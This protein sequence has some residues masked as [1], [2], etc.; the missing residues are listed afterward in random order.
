MFLTNYDDIVT[1]TGG[2]VVQGAVITV[3][4]W[5]GSAVSIYG[6][7]TGAGGA[8][9]GSQVT[10]N[11]YGTFSFYA[12]PGVYLLT[13]SN[14]PGAPVYDYDVVVGGVES[15]TAEYFGIREGAAGQVIT[16]ALQSWAYALLEHSSGTVASG[17]L[18]GGRIDLPVG[19]FIT[20]SLVWHP[21][22]SIFGA[23]RAG[24]QLTLAS[25]S[26]PIGPDNVRAMFYIL[27]R[28]QE[29]DPSGAWMPG[30]KHIRLEGNKTNQANQLSYGIYCERGQNDPQ[31]NAYLTNG[32]AK[33]YSAIHGENI[34]VEE[35]TGDG[36][37]F[38]GDRQRLMLFGRTR[39]VNHG[40]YSGGV[41]V[42]EGC[43]VRI[44]GNDPVISDCGFGSNT[45]HGVLASGCS[46][47]ILHGCNVWGA[48]SQARSNQCLALHVQNCNGFNITGNVFNDTVSFFGSALSNDD[49]GFSFTGNHCKPNK[50]TLGADGTPLG[51]ADSTCNAFIRVRGYKNGVIGPNDYSADRDGYRFEYLATFTEDSACYLEFAASSSESPKIIKPWMT[52]NP[53]P[54]MVDGSSTVSVV[55]HDSFRDMHRFSGQVVIGMGASNEPDP[56]YSLV[57]GGPLPALMKNRVHHEAGTALIPGM[58]Q[59]FESPSSGDNVVVGEARQ[60]LT[61]YSGNQLETLTVTLPDSPDDGHELDLVFRNGVKAFTLAMGSGSHVLTG[62]AITRVPPGTTIGLTFRATSPPNGEWW[63]TYT[64]NE[65]LEPR[66]TTQTNM[67][68]GG[69]LTADGSNVTVHLTKASTCT[70]FTV[71]LPVSPIDGERRRIVIHQEVTTWT[72]APGA[73][74]TLHTTDTWPTTIPAG[75]YTMEVQLVGTVWYRVH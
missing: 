7:R 39:S 30:F 67:T 61:V 12:R 14:V 35:F 34:E 56:D 37:R 44:H 70:A 6:S 66:G 22:L 53:V 47:L 21:A 4:R 2:A 45:G 25:N 36:M 19:Q 38:N 62:P 27:A 8:I 15:Y 41:T 65:G 13:V 3:T 55:M 42:T 16:S 5:D 10:T 9:S 46:G 43:G 26:T 57:H 11:A 64:R 28:T 18:P 75:G 31:Y 24:S 32:E 60:R 50:G 74:T 40:I 51:T 33:G 1:D 17:R 52:T 54:L 59:Q 73:G 49:R 58:A 48:A 29:S 72:L 68:N 69:A 20:D 63:Q 23:N 71:N